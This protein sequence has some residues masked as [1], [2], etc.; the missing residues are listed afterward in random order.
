MNCDGSNQN[1]NVRNS[2]PQNSITIK[3]GIMPIPQQPPHEKHELSV[4]EVLAICS[5][6]VESALRRWNNW[7]VLNS[8]FPDFRAAT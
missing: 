1:L 6:S 7:L 3:T 5:S 4:L 2:G 8:A